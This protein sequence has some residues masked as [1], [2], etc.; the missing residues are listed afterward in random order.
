MYT[1]AHTHTHT[2]A[3]GRGT[4]FS[5]AF[6]FSRERK[7]FLETIRTSTSEVIESAPFPMGDRIP[8]S[9][10]HSPRWP[11]DFGECNRE[12]FSAARLDTRRAHY[13]TPS[14]LATANIAFDYRPSFE[15]QST[16]K[17]A[18]IKN[19]ATRRRLQNASCVRS[20]AGNGKKRKM[21]SHARAKPRY[22]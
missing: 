21:I 20:A 18:S 15:R 14:R 22:R 4:K 3:R 11:S 13:K 6:R 8:E 19:Y 17:T 10:K 2:R 5:P 7:F 9:G 1:H 12:C 16:L